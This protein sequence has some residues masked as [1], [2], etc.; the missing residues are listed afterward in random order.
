[1]SGRVRPT[2]SAR[3]SS[4]RPKNVARMHDELARVTRERDRLKRQ[5]ERLKRHL[6]AARRAGFR[7][8]AP[9]A[10]DRPQGRGLPRGR[11]PGRRYGPRAR[12]AIPRHVASPTTRRCRP[13][14]LCG[15]AV[16]LD[17]VTPQ[18]QEDLPVVRPIVRR[19][20]GRWAGV[21]RVVVASKARHPLLTSDALWGPPDVHLG[22]GAVTLIELLHKHVGASLREGDAA[23]ALRA[24]VTPGRSVQALHRAARVAAPSY[25][26]LCAQCPWQSGGQ[27]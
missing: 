13:G 10:K 1:M 19:F 22:P 2:M 16:Q 18:Y 9:F 4:S 21:W 8:A 15:S 6:D 5:N 12:R 23:R 20:D 26:A 14:A 11:R 27:P 3:G 25:A 24:T 7:Q 17:R